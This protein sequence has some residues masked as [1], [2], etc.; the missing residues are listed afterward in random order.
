MEIRK[1]IYLLGI[2]LSL[3][4]CE[5]S[6][7]SEDD[8]NFIIEDQWQINIERECPDTNSHTI[9]EFVLELDQDEE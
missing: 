6:E 7:V 1:F 5:T 8:N 4:N 3:S 9:S 2:I